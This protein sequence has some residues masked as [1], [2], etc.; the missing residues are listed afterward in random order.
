MPSL[1]SQENHRFLLGANF[2]GVEF[3]LPL[4]QTRSNWRHEYP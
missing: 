4:Q 1:D 2:A 3:V